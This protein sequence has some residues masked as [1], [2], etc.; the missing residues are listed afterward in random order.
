MSL[1]VREN[2]TEQGEPL[3][4]ASVCF[5]S[6]RHGTV[7]R[8]RPKADLGMNLKCPLLAIW[9]DRVVYLLDFRGDTP[10]LLAQTLSCNSEVHGR[11]TA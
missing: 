11:A 1:D 4:H 10:R 2:F 5:L 7:S 9:R 3:I 8:Q 6:V